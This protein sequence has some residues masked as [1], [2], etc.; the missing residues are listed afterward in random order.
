MDHKEFISEL[1]KRCGL[2]KQSCSALLSA[3]ERLLVE[4]AIELVP[5]DFEGFGQF[6]SSKHPEYIQENTETGEVVM[7]PPRI[8]YRFHSQINL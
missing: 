7:Y 8:T 1:Q 2:D 6:V 5:V 4:N 3:T